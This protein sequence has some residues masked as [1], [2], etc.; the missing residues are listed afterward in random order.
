MNDAMPNH[1]AYPVTRVLLFAW[2]AREAVAWI[3][4]LILLASMDPLQSHASF[5]PL[6]ATGIEWCPGC[7]LGHSLAWLFRA[8]FIRSFQEHW[9]GLPAVLILSYRILQIIRT[10]LKDFHNGTS[11]PIHS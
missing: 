2:K 10:N 6:A 1:S 5:C 4:G 11:N 8:E 9:L 7:G 3:V